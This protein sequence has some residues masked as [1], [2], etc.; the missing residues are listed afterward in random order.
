EPGSLVV[1]LQDADGKPR[2]GFVFLGLFYDEPAHAASTNEHGEARFDGV[3]A[4]EDEIEAYLR[5]QTRANIGRDGDPMPPDSELV[6]RMAFV[7]QVVT[8]VVDSETRVVLRPRPVGY[9]RGVLRP[10]RELSCSDYS[11]LW[12]ETR[13]NLQYTRNCNSRTGE[14]L[15][16]P[17]L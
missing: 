4:G 3:Q 16:G 5:G 14:F 8:T 11:L 6:G 13:G 2:A 9:V 7:R 10:A 12:I 15:L 1:R 17:F